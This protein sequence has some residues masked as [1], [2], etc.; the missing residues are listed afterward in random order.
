[1]RLARA[2]R[3]IRLTAWATPNALE[4]NPMKRLLTRPAG[5][6]VKSPN[7]NGVPSLLILFLLLI[8]ISR[9]LIDYD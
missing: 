8:I 9:T 3:P 2:N 5:P 7:A 1:M 4:T 6:A